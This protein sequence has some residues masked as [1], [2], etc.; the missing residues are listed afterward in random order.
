MSNHKALFLD[1]DGVINVNHGYVYKSEDI[2][3]IDGIFDLIKRFVDQGF[4]PV[5]IT[6]Q[7]GIA[8]GYFTEQQFF[9]VMEHIQKC[10]GEHGLPPIPAFFC[11]HHP[12]FQ[13]S[14]SALAQCECRKPMPG[15]ILEASSQYEIDLSQS[16]FLGDKLTDIESAKR[17]GVGRKILY[18]PK[19]EQVQRL[20]TPNYDQRAVT[21]TD[22]EAATSLHAIE[23]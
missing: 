8:R 20:N 4:M 7:S 6:N 22:F 16:V 18:D 15:M 12:D 21:E 14:D 11:P 23:A 2:D 1:R 5:I 17:A 9:N 13:N 3:F 10:F 19:S